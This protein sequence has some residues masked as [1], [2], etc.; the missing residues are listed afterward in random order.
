MGLAKNARVLGLGQKFMEQTQSDFQPQRQTQWLF[1]E[2]KYPADT[3]DKERRRAPQTTAFPAQVSNLAS[4][5]K[6]FSVE[7]NGLALLT[8][9]QQ[10]T[11]NPN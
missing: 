11:G 6:P 8:P 5:Q 7:L 10:S 2:V 3:W 9:C 4:N 1:G